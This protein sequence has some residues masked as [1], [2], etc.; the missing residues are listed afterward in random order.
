MRSLGWAWL[1]LSPIL[2][3]MAAISTVNS[4]TAYHLQLACFSAVA[5]AGVMGSAALLLGHPLGRRILQV[6]SWLGFAYF[7]GAAML[8]PVFHLFRAPEVTLSSLATVAL[9][10]GAIGV[11]GV[12]FLYMARK[13]GN[14]Q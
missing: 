9:I 6:L 1:V 2:F 12:P 13:L 8:I 7:V 4:E 11:F 5:L 3:L 14:A 10:A